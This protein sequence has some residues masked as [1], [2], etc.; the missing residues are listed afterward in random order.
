MA[1][2]KN[3]VVKKIG[4]SASLLSKPKS[5]LRRKDFKELVTLTKQNS[6]LILPSNSGHAAK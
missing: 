2:R 4:D 1:K 5:I 6:A 3:N